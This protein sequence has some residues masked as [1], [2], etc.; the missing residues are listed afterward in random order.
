MAVC[1][2]Q[3][4]ND[5][6]TCAALCKAQAVHLAAHP[7]T[8]NG[9]KVFGHL[10]VRPNCLHVVCLQVKPLLWEQHRLVLLK[11][12]SQ[13]LFFK[14]TCKQLVLQDSYP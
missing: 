9:N 6:Q 1:M 13:W 11:E 12:S 8:S 7:F 4:A 2:V 10:E 5:L 14:I 3:S